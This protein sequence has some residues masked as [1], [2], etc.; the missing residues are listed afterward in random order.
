VQHNA[1]RS[2]NI[3]HADHC[4]GHVAA[5]VNTQRVSFIAQTT[6]QFFHASLMRMLIKNP[7]TNVKPATAAEI[8]SF[9]SPASPNSSAMMN[10]VVTTIVVSIW[11]VGGWDAWVCQR[12]RR[13][14][15]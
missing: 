9:L 1:K 8:S 5:R 15:S 2:T 14:S 12:V 6:H 7:M 13:R 11:W 4:G 3:V 10:T